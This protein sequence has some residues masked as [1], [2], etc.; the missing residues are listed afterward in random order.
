MITAGVLAGTL[1]AG[2]D[3]RSGAP[4][5]H[6]SLAAGHPTT[7]A[8]RPPIGAALPVAAGA[9]TPRVDCRHAR[10]VAL[11]F[12]DGP[13]IYT[14]R[15]L[16]TLR[17]AHVRATFFML[18]IQVQKFPAVAR[19]VARAGQEIGDH[20]WDHQDLTQLSPEAA[21]AEIARAKT[22]IADTIDMEPALFRPPYGSTDPAVAHLIGLLGMPVILWNVDTLD[23]RDRYAD[24]VSQRAI[25]EARPGS[26]ILMHD[27]YPSTVDAV[28]T[29][30]KGLRQRG[31]ILV[32]VSQLLASTRPGQ[33]YF[34]R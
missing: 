18:G 12:D 34:S 22:E 6:L 21:R 8:A 31:F 2:L 14:D 7:I 23:W 27:I 32:T 24:V 30:I 26:I 15:L 25:N 13:D 29:I 28:P 17:A 20:T 4:H 5:D 9:R 1:V 3:P 19:H 10:C 16:G 11:T 33:I